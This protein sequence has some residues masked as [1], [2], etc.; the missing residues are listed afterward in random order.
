LSQ[1]ERREILLSVDSA[2]GAPNDLEAGA[3]ID[4][5]DPSVT[6]TVTSSN[7][8]TIDLGDTFEILDP[9]AATP[10]TVSY[11]VRRAEIFESTKELIPNVYV[12]IGFDQPGAPDLD[13]AIPL[14][15]SDV[16]KIR[17]IYLKTSDGGADPFV[18]EE[19]GQDVT[20][21]FSFD[22]GQRDNYYDHAV[23]RPS[24]ITLTGDDWL[25]VKLDYFKS[26]T[27]SY[28]SVDSYPIDDTI[29]RDDAIF[30]YQIPKYTTSSGEEYNLRDS[31]DF[32]PVK[33][34][35]ASVATEVV[36]A[37]TNPDET[38]DFI[39]NATTGKLLIPLPSSRI[40][41]DYSYYLARRDILTLDRKGNFSTIRGKPSLSPIT[42]SVPENVMPI[43]K[44]FVPPYPSLSQSFARIL[45]IN[46]NICT[47]ER[48]AQRRFT[49]QDIGTLQDRIDSLEYYNALNLLEKETSDIQILDEQGLDRFKNGFLAEGFL[50][51]SLGDTTNNDYNIAIDR[52]KQVARPVFEL[53]SFGY[54]YDESQSSLEKIGN[55]V[56]LPVVSEETLVSYDK[57]TTTRNVEQSVYRFLGNLELDPDNDT[58]V[59]ETTVDKNVEFG[60]D[61][62]NDKLVTTDWGSWERNIVGANL[63]QRTMNDRSGNASRAD[64]YGSYSS[65]ADALRASRGAGKYGRN[66]TLIE[67][68]SAEQ[69][70]GIQTTINFEKE[71]QEL[72][73]FV[74]D[75]SV[76][77]YIRPQAI[78]FYASGIKPRTRHFMFFDGEDVTEYI[79]QYESVENPDTFT[80]EGSPIRS[81]EFGEIRGVLYLPTEG[82]RFRVGTKEVVLTDNLTNSLED[83]TSRAEE[84]FIAS[85]LNVQRQNTTL[86]TK[87]PVTGDSEEVFETRNRSAVDTKVIGPSCIAYTFEVNVPPEEEGVYVTSLDLFFQQ[88]HPELGFR[89]QIRELN[90]GG[91][92]TQNVIPYSEVWT[93]RKIVDS[94][95]NRIDNPILQT[96]QDGTAP[97]NIEFKAPVF[98]Y[99]ETSY[100]IVVSAENINPDT[101]LWIGRI[102]E[103]DLV[104]QEPVTSRRLTGAIFTTN[105][106]TNWDIVPQADL[107][108]KLY[109]A[110]FE[111]NQD[112]VAIL[113]NKPYEY[114]TLRNVESTYTNIGETVT[115]TDRI[116]VSLT[117]GSVDVGYT[118]E[119]QSSNVEGEV[120][121]VDG[122]I[123]ETTARGLE[124]GETVNFIDNGS[125][126]A[127]GSITD[128]VHGK[129]T[130]RRFKPQT[131]E[132]ILEK[133]NGYFF[134]DGIIRGDNTDIEST[135]DSLDTWPYSTTTLKPD[136]IDFQETSV[137]FE[138]RGRLSSDASFGE[139]EEGNED[140]RTVFDEEYALL[141]R[142]EEVRLFGESEYSADVRVTMSSESEYVS[143]V[144]DLS[145]A[146]SVYVHNLINDDTDGEDES[147]GGNLINKYIT[148]TITLDEGQDAEDLKLFLSVY[149]PPSQTGIQNDIKVW[150]RVRNDEDP[151]SLRNRPWMEMVTNNNSLSSLDNKDDFVEYEYDV[152][153][154]NLDQNGIVSYDTQ[155]DSDPVTLST[156]K[157][158]QIKIGL[159]GENSA[160]VPNVGD[161]RAIALQ[162]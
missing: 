69:R 60:D 127:T 149:R 36:E 140:N 90:S 89:T 123:I 92:I 104:T 31:L 7:T 64:Y 142:S 32:R 156:F 152:D 39:T 160:I 77:P 42:P 63:Y 131:N 141:S 95:G 96:S 108:F 17:A 34:R 148:K 49:M 118:V 151:E 162:K 48:I 80:A 155:I 93:D 135:I 21:Q 55:L 4:L 86:S 35:T 15:F 99:N 113:K 62:P 105:N 128:L 10:V 38:N 71:T 40:R 22:N 101:Y 19:D 44:I 68:I 75:V 65:Y 88:F 133:T 29:E 154:A 102:G 30:T 146:H 61:L 37:T 150:M 12:K 51:H 138:K 9:G 27:H 119:G 83:I 137:G 5:S 106:G 159:I 67:R 41:M 111:T 2:L 50:D 115:G 139:Y 91:N 47:H 110:K 26:D 129:A 73:N 117:G 53:D 114:L 20:N 144:L 54:D 74:T 33:T 116:T 57:A 79:R 120:L 43:A 143:P 145:R 121:K 56:H 76:I 72:G 136:F 25:L 134:K 124:D 109:R 66:R 100:A 147:S 6:V 122:Q 52:E 1:L 18:D 3:H 78:N 59:D 103:T 82:K 94:S 28:F 130:L 81:N 153:P 87:I 158:Y 157:Q 58:W 13:G 24:G 161:L 8:F 85:G 107:K 16:Y 125:T 70:S 45:G 98:L 112:R 23:I 97:T 46:D 132:M 11:K 14:G 126:V 84:F